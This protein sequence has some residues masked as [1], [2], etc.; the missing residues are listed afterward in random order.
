MQIHTSAAWKPKTSSAH[1]LRADSSL[2][3]ET[4]KICIFIYSGLV[5][6]LR[7]CNEV[8]EL[9]MD[10]SYQAQIIVLSRLFYIVLKYLKHVWKAS[11]KER[12]K[13]WLKIGF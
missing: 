6:I 1:T 11:L 12:R 3:F 13:F 9:F 5:V 4:E 8:I 2:N 7:I 10:K